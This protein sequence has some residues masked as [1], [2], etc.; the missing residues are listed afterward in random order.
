ME[1]YFSFLSWKEFDKLQVQYLFVILE[2]KFRNKQNKNGPGLN[3]INKKI[4]WILKISSDFED[5]LILKYSVKKFLKFV[6]PAA[7]KHF[8]WKFLRF[9]EKIGWFKI[10][11]FLLENFSE[12]RI[13]LI[14][15]SP[16]LNLLIILEEYLTE[17]KTCS[18]KL[19]GEN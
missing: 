2:E 5:V 4:P 9:S 6:Q 17:H 18:N 11:I 10:F 14:G 15:L 19:S 12:L 3:S 13:L 16:G 1:K 7:P 8:V